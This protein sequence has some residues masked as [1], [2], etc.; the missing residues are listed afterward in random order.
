MKLAELKKKIGAEIS[1]YLKTT[2]FTYKERG[3]L[4][5]VIGKNLL[6]GSN[7]FWY[8]GLCDFVIEKEPEPRPRKTRKKPA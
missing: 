3:I 4:R 8:P 1:F 6:V 7:F 5:E 2:G